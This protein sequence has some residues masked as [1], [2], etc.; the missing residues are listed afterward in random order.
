MSGPADPGRTTETDAGGG[1]PARHSPLQ[2]RLGQHVIALAFILIAGVFVIAVIKWRDATD[3]AT[4]VAVVT[5]VI[6]TLVGTFFGLQV[7]REQAERAESAREETAELARA[8]SEQTALLA[9]TA[10][11]LAAMLPP[12]EAEEVLARTR[13]AGASRR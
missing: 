3:V 1:T 13:T 5:G 9:E 4:A 11:G 8:T 12:D 6:G 10:V 7:G 2:L